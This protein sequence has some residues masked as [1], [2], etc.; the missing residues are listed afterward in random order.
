[1]I[2]TDD[3]G[4]VGTVS[5]GTS[6]DRS[7][8][9]VVIQHRSTSDGASKK[10]GSIGKTAAADSGGLSGPGTALMSKELWIGETHM[11]VEASR[12]VT[13]GGIT[14]GYRERGRFDCETRSDHPGC[15]TRRIAGMSWGVGPT[16]R[17]SAPSSLTVTR[18]LGRRFDIS[19]RKFQKFRDSQRAGGVRVCNSLW[20]SGL[21]SVP[22]FW[23][24]RKT[25][26]SRMGVNGHR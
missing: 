14:A 5:G 16:D 13:S 23:S 8:V 7:V 25:A 3:D 15:L 4:Q 11:S 10:R 9:L 22:V 21:Q 17:P 12:M 18:I 2:T 1:M 26:M 6:K 19:D 24:S 20:F